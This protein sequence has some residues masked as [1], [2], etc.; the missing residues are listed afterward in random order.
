MNHSKST[1]TNQTLEA[2]ENDFVD[3]DFIDCISDDS[4]TPGGGTHVQHDNDCGD[5]GVA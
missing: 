2:G 3:L 1:E 4:T 5:D